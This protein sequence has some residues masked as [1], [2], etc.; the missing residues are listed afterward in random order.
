MSVILRD[1]EPLSGV[2]IKRYKRFFADVRLDDGDV[3]TAICA[4]TGTMKTCCEP[5][6][7]VI[8]SESPNPDRKYR[9]TWELIQ[10][11]E[12]WVNVNTGLPNGATA[13][14]LER[15]AVAGLPSYPYIRREVK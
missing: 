14:L 7:P 5:G 3:V 15:G 8:L 9:L 12:S 2:L 10:M 13:A 11:G 4:N 6:R 1:F